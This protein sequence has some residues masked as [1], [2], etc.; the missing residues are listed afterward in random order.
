MS[1]DIFTDGACL[2]NPGPGGWGVVIVD[3]NGGRQEFSGSAAETTNNRMELR[4]VIEALQ[5]ARAPQVLRIHTDSQYVKNG[6]TL[7]IKTWQRNGWRTA[8]KKP[9]KNQDLWQEL[10]DLVSD[11]AIKWIWVKG[12]SGHAGNEAADALATEAAR[13]CAP[14]RIC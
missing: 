9:V 3:D 12:H 2:G 7:W 8:Q 11:R 4:A 13:G 6:I 14:E 1:L 10:S 5:I